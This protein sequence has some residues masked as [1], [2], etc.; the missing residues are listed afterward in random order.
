MCVSVCVRVCVYR[1]VN[2]CAR[3]FV[4]TNHEAHFLFTICLVCQF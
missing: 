1:R 2:V 4:H 3:N